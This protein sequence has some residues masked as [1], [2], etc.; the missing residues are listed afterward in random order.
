MLYASWVQEYVGRLVGGRSGSVR[1]GR[2][3]SWGAGVMNGGEGW[4]CAS[5]SFGV[6]LDRGARWHRRLGIFSHLLFS[7]L[8]SFVRLP[9]GGEGKTWGYVEAGPTLSFFI[10]DLAWPFHFRHVASTFFACCLPTPAHRMP[11]SLFFFSERKLPVP[12]GQ[13]SLSSSH[14]QQRISDR[15]IWTHPL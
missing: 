10:P 5:M 7:F 14:Q 15:N 11:S 6:S 4:A 9:H 13:D 2:C 3:T 12:R 8:F 1:G